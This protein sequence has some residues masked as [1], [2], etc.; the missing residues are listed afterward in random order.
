MAKRAKKR[1]SG[2]KKMTIPLAVVAGFAPATVGT[3]SAFQAGG[4]E[5]GARELSRSML[6]YDFGSGAFN[7]G[8]MWSGLFPVLM[9]AFVSRFVGGAMGVN[10]KLASMGVPLIRL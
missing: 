9:G 5:A 10:R 7:F 2:R 1:R 6:G 8:W 4:A 3:F